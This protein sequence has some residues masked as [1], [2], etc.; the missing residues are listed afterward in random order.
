[1]KTGLKPQNSTLI[2]TDLICPQ[3]DSFVRSLCAH[4]RKT[5]CASPLVDG[6][7]KRKEIAF[8]TRNKAKTFT[9]I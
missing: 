5:R 7:D 4:C 6:K 2:T 8:L 9:Q 3:P 1:M